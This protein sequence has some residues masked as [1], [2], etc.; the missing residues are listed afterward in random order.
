MKTIYILTLFISI[1]SFN[2]LLS[3]EPLNECRPNNIRKDYCIDK[4]VQNDSTNFHITSNSPDYNVKECQ[5]KIAFPIH[6]DSS[7]VWIKGSKRYELVQFFAEEEPITKQLIL[8][9]PFF[10]KIASFPSNYKQ[11]EIK[12]IDKENNQEILTAYPKSKESLSNVN[13]NFSLLFYGCFQPFK[14]ENG[15]GTV[16]HSDNKL[17]YVIRQTF[18]AVANSHKFKYYPYSSNDSLYDE[19][20]HN[21]K[22]ILG[23]GDQIYTDAG[24]G[25]V[26][27]KDHPL[28]AWA[29]R[30][31]DPYPLFGIDKYESH[32]NKCYKHFNSF[33]C[34]SN[35]FSKLPSLSVWDDHE[36]RDGWG[37]HGDEYKTNGEIS[38]SLKPYYNLSRKAYID[39]QL[40]TG[41]K[42][43]DGLSSIANKSLEQI[44]SING[45]DV[46]AFDL[47]SN[48]N[49]CENQV[50]DTTQ[51]TTFKN[52]CTQLVD[53]KEAI[54][55][56]SIPL[57]YEANK[58]SLAITKGLYQGELRDDIIDSWGSKYNKKQRD[59]IIRELI[60]LRKRNVKPIIISG[61]VHVGGMISTYYYNEETKESETLCYEFIFSGLSH[62]KLGEG[63]KGTARI[64][65]GLQHHAE[66][67]R[68]TDG[69]FYV[70]GNG[71]FPVYEFTRGR[72]NFGGLEFTKGEKTKA[73]LFVI[74]D[75]N[76]RVI[77][78]ELVLNW[79]RTLSEYWDT[80][81]KPIH[82]WLMPWKWFAR[83]LP[84]IPF[85]TVHIKDMNEILGTK[86]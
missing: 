13:E 11:V 28:S 65:S 82:W 17:N 80:T 51:M 49:S 36:I 12:F 63:R 55:I 38:D 20:I 18:K 75:K 59:D 30:C 62:E 54:I 47:R 84:D 15:K 5:A 8:Q 79:D 78:R 19:L 14:V 81:K 44:T 32:L 53:G 64:S 45:I 10:T 70:D 16:L 43:I 33:D 60:N 25:T 76:L 6:S 66:R 67:V 39:H 27:F 46:F 48:R 29:H 4:A 31:A 56:S 72:L 24:Y 23:T 7:R 41:P 61:D 86:Y 3:Q 74:G 52:W 85:N 58:V 34:F 2:P 71:V 35:I 26:E 21:P 83:Q 37:S 42:E 9:P 50:I 1:L 73:S 69:T 57:F 77:E 22:A 68:S 40:A